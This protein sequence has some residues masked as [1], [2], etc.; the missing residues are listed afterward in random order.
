MMVVSL[1]MRPWILMT[2]QTQTVPRT[3]ADDLMLM[4]QMRPDCD[5]T[6]GQDPLDSFC[7]GVASTLAYITDMGGK[8]S[9]SKIAPVGHLHLSRESPTRTEVGRQGAPHPGQAPHPRPGL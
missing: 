3:L 9:V 2:R 8:P 4:I 5:D 7:K 1:F 6:N